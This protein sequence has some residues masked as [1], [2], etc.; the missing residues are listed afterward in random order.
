MHP[1][2][3]GPVNARRPEQLNARA[4][5]DI[6]TEVVGAVGGAR[7][8][9]LLTTNNREVTVYNIAARHGL[10]ASAHAGLYYDRL[11][12]DTTSGERSL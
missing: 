11:R 6:W 10:I 12:A 3:R 5:F 8:Y 2:K 7:A 1:T 9:P 4:F